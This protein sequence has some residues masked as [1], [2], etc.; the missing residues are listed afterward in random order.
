MRPNGI[1]LMRYFNELGCKR[2][3]KVYLFGHESKWHQ[4][5]VSMICSSCPVSNCLGRLF[6]PEACILSSISRF[7]CTA[8]FFWAVRLISWVDRRLCEISLCLPCRS[9]WSKIGATRER[10]K[11][12]RS[13][14]ALWNAWVLMTNRLSGLCSIQAF[15]CPDSTRSCLNGCLPDAVHPAR[16]QSCCTLYK[17]CISWISN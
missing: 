17:K 9:G 7:F 11:V 2:Y 6:D 13:K 12:A 10:G 15:Q 1:V 14:C 3:R 4:R 16:G 8:R 5:S